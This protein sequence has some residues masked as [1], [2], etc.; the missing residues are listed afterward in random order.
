MGKLGILA[1]ARLQ[2]GA[3]SVPEL[4]KA[5]A[6]A[7]L[8]LVGID[9]HRLVISAT[10][11]ADMIRA[12]TDGPFGVPVHHVEYERGVDGNRGVQAAGRLPGAVPHS[13]HVFAVRAGVMQRQLHLVARDRIALRYQPLNPDLHPLGSWLAPD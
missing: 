2:H 12:A 10:W 1:H 13:A 4:E 9:R 8:G 7:R 3:G 6:A 11:M 5:R